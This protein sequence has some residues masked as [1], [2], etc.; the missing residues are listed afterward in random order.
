MANRCP[1]CG[2]F[3]SAKDTK[4]SNCGTIIGGEAKKEEVKVVK[5][6]KPVAPRKSEPVEVNEE[7]Y[8][9][10]DAPDV[11]RKG[12]D[13]IIVT[14]YRNV[15][16]YKEPK[17]DKPSYFD[18]NFIQMVGWGLLGALVTFFT[19]GILYPL[20]YGWMI[21]WEC[22]HTVINGYRQVFDGKAASLIGWWILW[23]FLTIITLTIFGWWTPLRLRRWKVKRI[24][25]VP[26][27]RAKK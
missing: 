19:L 2:K 20:A 4:C 5:E 10:S 23:S 17:F 9:V 12:S 3:L 7:D 11:I 6:V 16:V 8:V 1:N 15:V 21:K 18:G 14:S 13:P 26:D 27:T 25:L 24:K 22:R